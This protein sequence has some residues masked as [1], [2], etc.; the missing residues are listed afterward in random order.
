MTTKELLRRLDVFSS[1]DHAAL[2]FNDCELESD[3]PFVFRV[4]K[5]GK[6]SYTLS[7]YIE[8]S[9]NLVYCSVSRFTRSAFNVQLKYFKSFFSRASKSQQEY[10]CN[11][12]LVDNLL[13]LC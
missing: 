3:V 7:Y 10:I 1:L 4:V 6:V 11:S 2:L 13:K 5:D 9:D 12:M 8:L